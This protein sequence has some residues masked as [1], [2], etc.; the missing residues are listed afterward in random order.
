MQQTEVVTPL[1]S[2]ARCEASRK[3]IQ[4]SAVALLCVLREPQAVLAYGRS[5]WRITD[6]A[7]TIPWLESRPVGRAELRCVY[8]LAH[9]AEW[10]QMCDRPTVAVGGLAFV[11]TEL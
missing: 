9:R 1:D 8:Q 11:D 3:I 10:V 7:L 2:S 5:V 4:V 6:E